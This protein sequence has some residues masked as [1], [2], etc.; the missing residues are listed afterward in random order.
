MPPEPS[1]PSAKPPCKW[2]SVNL[3]TPNSWPRA[4]VWFYRA[5][6][7]PAP[8]SRRRDGLRATL[9]NPVWVRTY[10]AEPDLGRIQPGMEVN[11]RTDTPGAP[12]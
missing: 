12:F 1:S 11:V 4:R 5:C 8:S 10:V 3:P 2:L 9:T 6:A 7:R